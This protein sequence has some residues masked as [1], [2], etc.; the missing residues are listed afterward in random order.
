MGKT[1]HDKDDAID[2]AQ[3]ILN[4]KSNYVIFDTETTGVGEND[5]IVQIGLLDLDGNELMNTLI[6]PTKRKRI[7]SEATAIH[8]ITMKILL[9]APTF[10][11]IY[12]RFAMIIRNKTVLIY[13]A[14]FDSKLYW[15][16]S[17]QD[18][19]DSDSYNYVCVMLLYSVFVGDW[20]EY[21]GNFKYQRLPGGDHTAIGDC[22]ATLELLK[23]M[24]KAKKTS[25]LVKTTI[26]EKTSP[27]EKT[28]KEEKTSQPNRKWWQFW[29]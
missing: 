29:L 2:V 23:K 27:A 5:V 21:H 15:Q 11:E 25:L 20:S 16:T 18:D 19:I 24:A 22:K 10:K 3:D 8:G 4:N 6:K 7:S 12:P 13:N 1:I 14:E 26:V 9:D 17:A 28:S